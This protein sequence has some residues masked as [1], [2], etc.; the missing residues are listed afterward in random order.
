M[1]RSY[2][3]WING[4]SVQSNS[5]EFIQRTSPAH[6]ELL[7]AFPAG[8]VDD[9]NKAVA[10]ARA[11]FEAKEWVNTPSL[12]KAKVLNKLA[13]L[14]QRDVEKLAIIEA[15]E[16]GKTINQARAEVLWAAELT[17]YAA[18]ISAEIPGSAYNNLGAS[19]FGIV[20]HEPKGVVGMITP[21]NFPLVTLFQKL[22]YALA[23]GC[24][25]VI[26]PSEL[27]AGTT[28]EVAKL[29]AEAG[30]PAGLINVVTGHGSV[31]GEALTT[32]K[33]VDMVSFTGSTAV[34]KRIAEHA[35]KDV[36]RV[37]L[38]LG[39]KAANVVFADADIDAAIDGVL[40]GFILNQGEECVAGTRLLIEESVADAF[41]VE[42]VKRTEKV[43]V[44]LP[45]DEKADIGSMI[46]EAQMAK[47]L[48]YIEIGKNEGATLV[49]GGKQLTMGEFAKGYFIEPTIFTNV[50]PEMRVFREEIFGPVLTV[51]KF[52]TVDEAIALANDTE[53]GLGNG[54]W[55][56][57][58]DKAITVSQAL[59]SGT[60]F[61]N[62]F[63]ETAP[64]LPFGG[65]K[66]SGIG[67]ENGIHGILEFMEV[68]STFIKI[69]ARTPALPHTI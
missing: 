42:L 40:L 39:G 3:Q 1:V 36:R 47:V 13:D 38:E 33:D 67:R 55:T 21:W 61:V 59:R 46:H 26:K 2:M 44:G 9:V 7:A 27:T 10:A 16:V 66:N 68:K 20:T 45:L 64:Q 51:T 29:A 65:F 11:A 34:G 17:R 52:K 69:G 14:L 22:P 56:K 57:D 53:Y 4:Q 23:A 24:A 8:S 5:D 35:A 43:R 28:F 37:G 62:T 31:V 48:E 58:I 30:V 19:A 18:A 63:L 41:I 50:S 32:H 12:N 60:V 15:E 54:L 25:T 49:C 6:G